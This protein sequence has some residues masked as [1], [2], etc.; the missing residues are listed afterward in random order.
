MIHEMTTVP[1]E[2]VR[3]LFQTIFTGVPAFPAL[4]MLASSVLAAMLAN[5]ACTAIGIVGTD[6]ER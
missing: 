6:Q 3:C 2:V 5:G 1:E 4:L